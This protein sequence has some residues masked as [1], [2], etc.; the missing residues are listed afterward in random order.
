MSAVDP[1][2]SGRWRILAVADVVQLMVVLDATV[3]N[4][5][6]PSAQR[7]VDMLRYRDTFAE[8][9]YAWALAGR[10]CGSTGSRLGRRILEP[11]L[12]SERTLPDG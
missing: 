1:T 11:A 3:V 12:T 6:L 5:G 4:I 8:E 10:T 9:E 2:H 7:R